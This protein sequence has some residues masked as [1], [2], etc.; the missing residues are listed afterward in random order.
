MDEATSAAWN[1]WFDQ[2]LS[3]ALDAERAHFERRLNETEVEILKAVADAF[4]VNVN[5]TSKY[6]EDAVEKGIRQS[7]EHAKKLLTDFH[8]TVR[9]VLEGREPDT[10]TRETLN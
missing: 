9:N 2:R 3:A 7:L 1:R 6:I 4:K 10:G 8:G 5:A